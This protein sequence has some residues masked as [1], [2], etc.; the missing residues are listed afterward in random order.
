MCIQIYVYIYIMYI[1]KSV[2]S[3]IPHALERFDDM[4]AEGMCM[5]WTFCQVD[6]AAFF[7]SK[8]GIST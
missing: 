8:Q 6:V 4:S 7:G 5:S 3:R 2:Y 1:V